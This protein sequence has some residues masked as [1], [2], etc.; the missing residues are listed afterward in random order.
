MAEKKKQDRLTIDIGDLR[1]A[2]E[3]CREDAAWEELSLAGKIRTLVKERI[4]QL[5]M[6]PS[7]KPEK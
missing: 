1:E 3:T 4:E 2:I 7:E 5:T 6:T